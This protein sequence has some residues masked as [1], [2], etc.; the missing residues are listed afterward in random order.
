MTLGEAVFK[1]LENILNERRISMYK[2]LKDNAIPWSTMFNLKTGHTKS[3]SLNVIF[4]ISKA[5]CMTHLEFLNDSLFF[6]EEI[7]YL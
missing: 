5:L 7:D 2:F 3:P 4:Q 6:N 1:R